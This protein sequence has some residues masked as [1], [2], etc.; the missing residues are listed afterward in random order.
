MH[1]LVQCLPLK[2]ARADEWLLMNRIKQKWWSVSSKMKLLRAGG[3][4]WHPLG[5]GGLLTQREVSCHA[6]SCPLD[7]HS[8]RTR[9]W[10]WSPRITSNQDLSPHSSCP[11]ETDPIHYNGRGLLDWQTYTWMDLY[12]WLI[13]PMSHPYILK[14]TCCHCLYKG[15]NKVSVKSLFL[16]P[17]IGLVGTGPLR[18]GLFSARG[19]LMHWLSSTSFDAFDFCRVDIIWPIWL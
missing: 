12:G 8:H 2:C 14:V 10:R 5:H 7:I 4:S 11:Q 9:N 19:N 15:S 18:M 6:V 1:T 3:F 17:S 16:S 13:H